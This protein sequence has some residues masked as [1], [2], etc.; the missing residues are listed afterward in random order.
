MKPF[1]KFRCW[2]TAAVMAFCC[3]TVQAQETLPGA[4][5]Q[6]LLAYA[7]ERNPE[8]AVQIRLEPPLIPQGPERHL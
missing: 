4:D 3:F 7:R 2:L 5:V 1:T 8:S 6:S